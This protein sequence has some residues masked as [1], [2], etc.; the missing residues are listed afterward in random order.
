MGRTLTQSNTK[1]SSLIGGIAYTREVY[2]GEG[3]RSLA[4][5]VAGAS[6]EWFTFDGKSTS[7]SAKGLTYYA[8]ASEKRFR[9]EANTAFKSDIV[10][11]SVL[12]VERLRKLHQSPSGGREEERLRNL[13]DDRLVV[14]SSGIGAGDSGLAVR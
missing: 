6:W 7:L 5:A 3:D 1:L 11:D 12:E 9:L 13:G 2:A 4:E 10:G 14:L 8:L